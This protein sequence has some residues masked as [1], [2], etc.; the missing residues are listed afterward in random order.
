MTIFLEQPR[1]PSQITFAGGVA[2]LSDI[3]GATWDSM[4]FVE[5]SNASYAALSEA[6]T[7]RRREIHAATGVE[8][9]DPLQDADNEWY[10]Q[11]YAIPGT[12][13]FVQIQQG[14]QRETRDQIIDRHLEKFR[15]Q[16]GELAEK[17]PDAQETIGASRDLW[18][19]ATEIA[20][21]SDQRL[22]TLMDSRGGLGKYGAMLLGG[23]GGALNDP[24]TILSL[25]VGAG[26]GMA[27]TI[28][29]RILA[30]A[31]KEALINAGTEAAAQ[32][33]VQAWRK[34]AG[35]NHGLDEALKNILFGGLIGG[36]FGAA[37]GAI[38][39]VF[40]RFA[41]RTEVD[42]ALE[43]LNASPRLSEDAR[44]ILADDGLR[45]A[46]SLAE[47][48]QALPPEARGA[49][50][51]AETIRL[52]DELRPARADID[53]HDL[54]LSRA[55]TA[56]RM[57][58]VI[59]A[60]P[61][62]EPD[63]RQI[64]RIVREIAGEPTETAIRVETPLINFL[65]N[66][67]GVADFKGELEA[68]GAA[69][70]SVRGRGRLVR[71][72]GESLDYAREAAAQEGFFDH[73]YGDPETAAA[74]STVADL[75]NV[76][77][78]EVRTRN[79][80]VR[81]SAEE[82]A[83]GTLEGIVSDIARIAGPN[84]DDEVI[85]RA[86][87]LAVDEGY[88]PFD[89]LERIFIRDELP[90]TAKPERIG[91]PLPGWSDEELLAT[92]EQRGSFPEPDG[93]DNPGRLEQHDFDVRELETL[94]DDFMIPTDDGVVSAAQLRDQIARRENLLTVVEACRI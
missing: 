48:R 35:L 23:M 67:G 29:G 54:A 61:G 3:A 7:R 85:L 57:P 70:I 6:L 81:S 8:L 36:A 22:A 68:I 53:A 28:A 86:A 49:L 94:P 62:F 79:S 77:E 56:I 39:E 16:L 64:E 92:S 44:A 66:R 31:G 20:R 15:T 34:K 27:R 40:G 83:L 38:V 52:A 80:G 24:L 17:F 46:D 30:V 59:D 89:A 43:A 72:N 1:T 26:P 75:L 25:G 50:D 87:R 42:R 33:A 55:D 45:A 13:A 2:T 4:L 60:W 91:D 71:K 21:T 19:D 76:L 82:A 65:I 51:A 78:D 5:N 74:R 9:P 41:G 47:I 11:Q 90:D 12:P 14:K 10:E 69:Q 73:L 84:I 63:R 18:K 32:P 58:D 88:E 93:I 37:G